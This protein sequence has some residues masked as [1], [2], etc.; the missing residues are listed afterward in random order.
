MTV[1]DARAQAKAFHQMVPPRLAEARPHWLE[2]VKALPMDG[3]ANLGLGVIH[4]MVDHRPDLALG[5]LA[6]AAEAMPENLGAI[7]NLGTAYAMLQ[8][9][10]DALIQFERSLALK[11]DDAN[12]HFNLGV[13]TAAVGRAREAM[14]HYDRAL[15][16]DPTHAVAHSN[17]I[18]M[19]DLLADDDDA[20]RMRRLWNE[21]HALP[22][23]KEWTPHP[24]DR[25]PGRRLR[26]GYVSGDVAF[27][28]AMFILKPIIEHHDRDQ[29]ELFAYSSTLKHDTYTDWFRDEMRWRNVAPA[30]PDYIARLIRRD[31][32]DILVERA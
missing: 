8:R 26:I 16:L 29:F 10:D 6:K 31:G 23:K 18:Y 21:R 22:L 5:P 32:I 25:T 19:R 3:E 4:I 9:H 12:T 17:A 20:A 7:S 30:P 13:I 14:V 2:V 24:N 28:S 11:P 1:D 27:H 15:E